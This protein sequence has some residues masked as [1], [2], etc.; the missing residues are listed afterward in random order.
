MSDN[1]RH[2]VLRVT[3]ILQYL[4]RRETDRWFH[5]SVDFAVFQVITRPSSY[6]ILLFTLAVTSIIGVFVA[7]LWR[8]RL[9]VRIML[10][11]LLK[12]SPN[13]A[14]RNTREIASQFL[15][16]F[17]ALWTHVFSLLGPRIFGARPRTPRGCDGPLTVTQCS[18]CVSLRA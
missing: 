11:N 12:L 1:E 2:V 5:S 7:D 16:S 14:L 10:R 15:L 4:M 8:F 6:P 18:F 9:D 3:P 13:T 17:P